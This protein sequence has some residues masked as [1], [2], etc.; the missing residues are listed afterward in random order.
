MNLLK[1]KEMMTQFLLEDIGDRDISAD[2]LF[3][4]DMIGEFTIYAKEH[5]VYCGQSIIDCGFLLLHPTMII[6]HFIQDGQSIQSGDKI[7]MITGPITYLLSGERV[8]LNLIQRLSAIS[9]LTAYAVA[10]TTNTTTRICDTRK[11]TPGL[12]LLEKYAVRVGGGFNHR[13]GLY[14]CVMLKDNHI[15][16]AGSIT[17]AVQAISNRIGHTVKIEVEVETKQ[18]LLEAVSA[19]VD[20][21][22]LDNRSPEEIRLWQPLIPASIITEVSGGITLATIPHYAQ[23]GVD[24]I[25]L[26]ALTHS[27]RSLNMSA[28]VR[29]KEVS[30]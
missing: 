30:H 24:W 7:A 8:I 19:G 6:T 22:M 10:Q 4:P 16:F 21:I 27:V 14:D 9:T 28:S 23:L 1:L 12:R 26:G 20:I 13:N 15:S 17:E 29:L 2:T 3:T 5:G 25:S 11:T 18:Q